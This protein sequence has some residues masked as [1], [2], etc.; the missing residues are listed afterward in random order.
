MKIIKINENLKAK[1]NSQEILSEFA[2]LQW[3]KYH[4]MTDKDTKKKNNEVIN[5]ISNVFNINPTFKKYHLQDLNRLAQKDELL[6]TLEEYVGNKNKVDNFYKLVGKTIAEYPLNL[7]WKYNIYCGNRNLHGIFYDVLKRQITKSSA[8]LKAP[9]YQQNY[10]ILDEELSKVEQQRE[11]DDTQYDDE[12]LNDV[13]GE[14]G[15]NASRYVDENF[16][17]VDKKLVE[18]FMGLTQRRKTKATKN[19]LSYTPNLNK[20]LKQSIQNDLL[21]LNY[22]DLDF[23]YKQNR[24]TIAKVYS[25][26]LTGYYLNQ[27]IKFSI[28][29]VDSQYKEIILNQENNF[30]KNLSSLIYSYF[31]SLLEN[32]KQ[33]KNPNSTFDRIGN[34]LRNVK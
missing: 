28:F 19:I 7:V 33:G 2:P 21:E 25:K 31:I 20:E 22:E 5:L 32:E 1:A 13:E 11:I 18:D 8:N 17:L 26:S 9:I 12:D 4:L 29:G 27:I 34:I 3:L 16:D 10:N 23:N 15:R 6:D 14:F 30:Q 24:I